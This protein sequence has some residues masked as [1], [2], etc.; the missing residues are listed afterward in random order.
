MASTYMGQRGVHGALSHGSL[1]RGGQGVDQGS[2]ECYRRS[3]PSM[4][5]LLPTIIRGVLTRV[6]RT[7]GL[8]AVVQEC[9]GQQQ[10]LLAA[11]F[12]PYTMI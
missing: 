9:H 8:N 4:I 1:A 10:Q 11:V 5:S 7:L 2:V 6:A 12:P 3:V